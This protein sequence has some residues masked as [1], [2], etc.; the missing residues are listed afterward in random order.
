MQTFETGFGLQRNVD[1]LIASQTGFLFAGIHYAELFKFLNTSQSETDINTL[2][3][4]ENI[5]Q[6]YPVKYQ[7]FEEAGNSCYSS[8]KNPNFDLNLY[9]IA[10]SKLSIYANELKTIINKIVSFFFTGTQLQESHLRTIK[11]A[12][13]YCLDMAPN[14]NYGII[15]F[16]LFLQLYIQ[17][18]SSDSFIKNQTDQIIQ[19]QTPD[20][21][22]N[23]FRSNQLDEGIQLDEDFQPLY[24]KKPQYFSVFF[25]NNNDDAN[26]FIQDF[27]NEIY[28]E[29]STS[30]AVYIKEVKW[31]DFIRSFYATL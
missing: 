28:R 3:V 27:I 4:I 23:I 7:E 9:Q 1:Y 22:I 11:Q 18:N 29:G 26:T 16:L 25:P 30:A 12:R 15:D 14:A 5:K 6:Y 20:N 8:K 21:F 17:Y 10:A 13:P 19:L 31:D 24:Y 2:Q